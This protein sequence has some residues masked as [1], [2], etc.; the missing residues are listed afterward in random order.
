MVNIHQ[1]LYLFIRQSQ[2]SVYYNSPVLQ[3]LAEQFSRTFNR[4]G[5]RKLTV[6]CVLSYS[7]YSVCVGNGNGAGAGVRERAR[8]RESKA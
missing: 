8:A 5:S 7:W 3:C 1:D 4:S 2:D 6:P